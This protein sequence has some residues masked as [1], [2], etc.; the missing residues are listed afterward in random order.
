MESGVIS[1]LEG[2]TN[3]EDILE[4]LDKK[5][6]VKKWLKE[7]GIEKTGYTL[8]KNYEFMQEEQKKKAEVEEWLKKKGILDN[9]NTWEQNYQLMQQEK[10]QKKEKI[11]DTAVDVTKFAVNVAGT[12]LTVA[13]TVCPVDGPA[14]EMAIAAATPALA[15][16]VENCRPLLKGAVNKDMSQVNAAMADLNGNV[17]NFVMKDANLVKARNSNMQTQT[18]ENEAMYQFPEMQEIEEGKGMTF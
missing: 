12:A 18:L 6:E 16:A 13:A 8:E 14:G 7:K 11:I 9:G 3:L 1:F 2:R 17:Q 15:K 4:N 10:M 5:R